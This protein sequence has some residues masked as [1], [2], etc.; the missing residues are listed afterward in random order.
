MEIKPAIQQKSADFFDVD[1]LLA[2]KNPSL[3]KFLPKFI[4]N[5]IKKITFD[6]GEPLKCKNSGLSNSQRTKSGMIIG[7]IVHKF[8]KKNNKYL[9]NSS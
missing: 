8:W 7:K 9:Q 6:F 2:N 4:L 5:Y 1:T 3:H